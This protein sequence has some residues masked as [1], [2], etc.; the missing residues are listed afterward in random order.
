LLRKGGYRAIY[1]ENLDGLCC[2]LAFDSK[3][4]SAQ[5]DAKLREVEQALLRASRNGADPIVSDTS[6]CSLR[7]KQALAAKLAV[8]DVTEFI[9]DQLLE[10]L[11]LRPL[12]TTVALHATCSVRKMNLESKLTGIVEA[13][14]ERV[15]VPEG[16][17]CCGWAGDKGFTQPELNAS[18]L[19][20][21]RQQ[22]PEGC[23]AG[24]S[25]NRTCEIGLSLHSGR[26][27]RSIV[28]LVDSASA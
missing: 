4:A 28:Y 9:H 6:P 2:G 24:Y 25:S 19:R 20:N 15:I 27:Y 12:A 17:D 23:T 18:A 8:L 5:A 21:L 26:Y 7:L 3:G 11:V 10:R 16:V 22:L 1:P 14:A 13:C